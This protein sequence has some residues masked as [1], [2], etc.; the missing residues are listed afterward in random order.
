MNRTDIRHRHI[1]LDIIVSV[2]SFMDNV[3]D[4]DV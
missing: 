3:G 1:V 4:I 2:A